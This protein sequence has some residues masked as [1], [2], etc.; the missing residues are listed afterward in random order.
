MKFARI[1]HKMLAVL[2]MTLSL[3][4]IMV[5]YYYNEAIEKSLL[6]EYERTLHRMTD[7]VVMSVETIMTEDH[8]EIMPEYARRLQALPGL[9]DFRIARRD[10]TE[11]YRDNSTI[12]AVNERL[13][14]QD[15]MPRKWFEERQSVFAADDAAV[16]LLLAGQESVMRR[17]VAPGGARV[18]HF[19]DTIPNSRR[20]ARC[21]DDHPIRGIIKVTASLAEIEREMAS[22]RIKALAILIV[23]LL[24][25]M[26]VTGYMLG[27]TIAEPIEQASE[28]MKKISGGNFESILSASRDDELGRMASSFNKMTRD[29]QQSYGAMMREREKLTTVIQGAGEAVVAANAEGKIVLANE[30]ACEMLGKSEAEICAGGIV[31]LVDQPAIFQSMLDATQEHDPVLVKYADRWLLASV[32]C[33][34]DEA[35]Q[36]IG[37][38]ALLRDVTR[39][40]TILAELRRLSTTD[41]LTDVYN[42]RHLDATL[43]SEMQRA[44]EQGLHLSVIMFD[45]DHFKKFND[46]YGHDQG[47]RVLKMVGQVMRKAVREYDVPCRYGGEEFAVILPCTAA[48]GAHVVAE[49][50]R[51]AVEAM[52]VDGLQVTI[53][54]GIATYPDL[55]ARSPEQLVA[56]ADAALYHSKE[57]GRNCSTIATTDMISFG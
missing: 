27:R 42:R 48:A 17:E 51:T 43:K 50:L 55:A 5:T 34:R 37:S 3:G 16:A 28:A 21:H 53:S 57:N 1:R 18:V 38:A 39:E 24:F 20:C 47:D 11:A 10:G 15:F 33:I 8:A 22:A 6:A 54:L 30:A 49:R 25:T 41:A 52:Q 9:M 31:A 23:A 12:S 35:G 45:A 32:S 29:V 14:S 36:V 40:Q 4:F 7:S 56:A 26:S 44:M 46:T 2:G 13:G 19:F